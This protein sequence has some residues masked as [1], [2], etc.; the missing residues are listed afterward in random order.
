GRGGRVECRVGVV[1]SLLTARRPFADRPLHF[2]AAVAQAGDVHDATPW[3]IN[4]GTVRFNN[5]TV[6]FRPAV[7]QPVDLVFPG[8]IH[9]PLVARPGRVDVGINDLFPLLLGGGQDFPG[10]VHDAAL[11]DE[12]EAALLAHPV[13]RRVVDVVL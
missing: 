9:H 11:A 1:S 4:N 12:A 2:R 5:G 13:H 7:G 6:H 8:D 10:A 3:D